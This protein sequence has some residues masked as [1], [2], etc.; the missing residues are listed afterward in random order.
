M[1]SSKLI[2]HLHAR[3]NAKGII[4]WLYTKWVHPTDIAFN[5]MWRQGMYVL[6]FMTRLGVVDS[7]SLWSMSS[8]PSARGT[9]IWT[10]EGVGTTHIILAGLLFA[11]SLWHWVYWDLDLFRD[12]R[13]GA[14]ALDLP[15]LFGIHLCLASLLCLGFGAF[16]CANYPGI[17][18]SDVYGLTGGVSPVSPVWDV[19]GFDAFNPGGITAHHIAAG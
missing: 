3:L 17:W 10:Y 14:L 2:K 13:T 7:W 12:R 19:S 5:P 1:P 6:P 15:K 8:N 9:G 4:Q 16:H 11:A 18:V